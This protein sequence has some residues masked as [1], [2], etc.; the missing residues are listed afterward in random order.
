M[1]A[2]RDAQ[3]S[4]FVDQLVQRLRK[5]YRAQLEKHENKELRAFVDAGIR[6]ARVYGLVTRSHLRF[7]IDLLAMHGKDFDA[8]PRTAWA[9]KILHDERL[10][11]HA[12][13]AQ[14]DQAQALLERSRA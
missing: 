11:P 13:V 1:V 7:Y 4:R 6:Q 14:L 8:S 12:K 2:L 3:R 5:S 10:D 9:G